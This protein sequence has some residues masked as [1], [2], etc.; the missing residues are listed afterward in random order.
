MHW[1]EPCWQG[2]SAWAIS[3]DAEDL[4][5]GQFGVTGVLMDAGFAAFRWTGHSRSLGAAAARGA[6]ERIPWGRV[7]G[8]RGQ[9]RDRGRQRPGNEAGSRPLGPREQAGGNRV[10]GTCRIRADS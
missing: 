6:L 2:D 5:P 3:G 7:R 8:G 10:P 1:S 9:H 4:N